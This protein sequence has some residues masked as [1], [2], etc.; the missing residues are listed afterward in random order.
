MTAGA[1][2][3]WALSE[4]D[5]GIQT[6]SVALLALAAR[7]MDRRVHVRPTFG[8]IDSELYQLGEG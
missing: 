5:C 8:T 6:T 7:C 2:S 3:F 4:A 1:M